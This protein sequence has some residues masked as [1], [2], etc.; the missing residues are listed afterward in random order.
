MPQIFTGSIGRLLV[1]AGHSGAGKTTFLKNSPQ[2]LTDFGQQLHLDDFHELASKHINTIRLSNYDVDRFENLCLHVDLSQ[3]IRWYRPGPKNRTDLVRIISPK[4]YE[5]WLALNHYLRKAETLDIVTYFVRRDIH[6]ARWIYDKGLAK[7]DGA[8]RVRRV[9]TAV[10]GDS[11]DDS[12]LHR[13]VYQ[14]WMGY[15]E[16][17]RARSNT[18]IDANTSEYVF[19]D[20]AD[21]QMEI[22]TKYKI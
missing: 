11:T 6:F 22:D 21:F 1:V 10:C 5:R 9:I 12:A 3:P 7:N 15:V 14:A 17:L 13:G 16:T 4:M 19:M 20:R 18:V 8:G 2:Y